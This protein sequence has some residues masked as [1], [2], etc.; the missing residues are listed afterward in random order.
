MKKSEEFIQKVLLKCPE[1]GEDQ[2]IVSTR[3]AE[4]GLDHL[5][6]ITKGESRGWKHRLYTEEV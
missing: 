2:R 4:A 6:I 5:E 1:T 3:G